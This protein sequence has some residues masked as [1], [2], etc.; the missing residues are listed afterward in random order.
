MQQNM[1]ARVSVIIPTQNAEANIIPLLG[2]LQSQSI[3][4]FEI[5]VVD[6]ESTDKTVMFAKKCGATILSIKRSAFNHGGTRDYAL[7]QSSGEYVLF[8]THDAIPRNADLI[9]NLLKAL[10]SSPNIAAVYGRHLPRDDAPFAERF[11]RNYN[12]PAESHVFSAKDIATHGIKTFF[13]SNVCALYR[14]DIYEELGGFESDILTNED[15]FY[16]ARAINNGYAICY[17]AKAEVIHSHNFS[18]K[19]QY[20]R[21]FLQGYEIERHKKLI[22]AATQNAEG[23][24]L[25]QSVTKE[26]LSRHMVFAWIHFALDCLARYAGSFMGK[27]KARKETLENRDRKCT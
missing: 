16:S 22:D 27:Q 11:I 7:K 18:F 10:N 4:P 26:L 23:L 24:R 21:N 6:S 5:I 17:A 12:Y 14:R 3:P 2:M 25:V 15:M 9:Y 8:L 20:Q 13:M 1:N 19:E